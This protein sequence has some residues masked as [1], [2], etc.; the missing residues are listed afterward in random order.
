MVSSLK[1]VASGQCWPR[2]TLWGESIPEARNWK[3]LLN[4]PKSKVG[5]QSNQIC[6]LPH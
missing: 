2:K 1:L 6:S 4:F 3:S 5:R